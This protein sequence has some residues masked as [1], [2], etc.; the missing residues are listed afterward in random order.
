VVDYAPT[1]DGHFEGYDGDSF[2]AAVEFGDTVHAKV[3][4]TYGN[5]SDPASPH[6]GDQLVLASKKEL[7]DAWLTREAV[8][9]NL[10]GR[11]DFKSDGKIIET[12]P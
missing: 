12:R 5:S 6:F 10:E 4:M 7:R 9:K 3:L 2:I 1:K 8:E 11:T